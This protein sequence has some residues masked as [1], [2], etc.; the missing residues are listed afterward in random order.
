MSN[1]IYLWNILKVKG[2]TCCLLQQKCAGKLN[3]TE[4]NNDFLWD[5]CDV[6]SLLFPSPVFWHSLGNKNLLFCIVL[7]VFSVS[8][9]VVFCGTGNASFIFFHVFILNRSSDFDSFLVVP[10]CNSI[11]LWVKY[12]MNVCNRNTVF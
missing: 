4:E 5:A 8:I 1:Y 12:L 7:P 3:Y 10:S 6:I 2:N 11:M 9:S